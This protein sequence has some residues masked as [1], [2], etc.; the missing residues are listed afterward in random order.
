[1]TKDFHVLKHQKVLCCNLQR[2]LFDLALKLP[3]QSWKP[4]ELQ[5]WSVEHGSMPRR[6]GL[7]HPRL[8]VEKWYNEDDEQTNKQR[9]I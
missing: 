3:E 8:P 7:R 6:F 9:V 1:M 4:P 5:F 2:W